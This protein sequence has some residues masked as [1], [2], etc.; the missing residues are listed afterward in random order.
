MGPGRGHRR[1]LPNGSFVVRPRRSLG[2]G[3]P[4]EWYCETLTVDKS[5]PVLYGI[6]RR[7][8]VKM[9]GQPHLEPI[10]EKPSPPR[11]A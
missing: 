6:V 2:R 1:Y 10:C 11:G 9:S 3:T 7:V 8:R 5:L 4:E